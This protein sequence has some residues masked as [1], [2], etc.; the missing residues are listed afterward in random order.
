MV[1]DVVK[2]ARPA[3]IQV[4]AELGKIGGTEKRSGSVVVMDW[5][6]YYVKYFLEKS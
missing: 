6:N 1:Q 3:G 4:E 2:V 5:Q